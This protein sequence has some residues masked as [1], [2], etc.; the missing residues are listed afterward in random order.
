MHENRVVTLL[1]RNWKIV[2]E[3]KLTDFFRTEKRAIRFILNLFYYVTKRVKSS[4]GHDNEPYLFEISYI[5][6]SMY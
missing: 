5:N 2:I 4:M 1:H 6:T 3:A